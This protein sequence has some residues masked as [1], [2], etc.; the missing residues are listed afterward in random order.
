MKE[1]RVVI[2]NVNLEYELPDN[3]KTEEEIR[4]FYE[5]VE[6]PKEYVE[7]SFEFVKVYPETE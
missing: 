2:V 7:D 6:L 3:V 1:K 4:N 5:N